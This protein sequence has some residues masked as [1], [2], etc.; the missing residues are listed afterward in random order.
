MIRYPLAEVHRKII[1]QRLDERLKKSK[2]AFTEVGECYLC[3]KTYTSW[4]KV[5]NA[6][7]VGDR[8]CPD[9]GGVIIIRNIADLT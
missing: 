9:C 2:G 4:K 8:K 1:V 7:T 3:G 6:K 5:S